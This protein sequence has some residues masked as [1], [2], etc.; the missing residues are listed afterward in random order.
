[1]AI[2]GCPETDP[3]TFS[4]IPHINSRMV[5]GEA[6]W[7]GSADDGGRCIEWRGNKDLGDC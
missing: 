2:D 6:A 3:S 1:M 7:G 4:Y 5:Q